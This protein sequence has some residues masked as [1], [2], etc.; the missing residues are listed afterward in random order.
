VCKFQL[1]CQIVQKRRHVEMC[2]GSLARTSL[3]RNYT[4]LTFYRK[5]RVFQTSFPIKMLR[6]T[7]AIFRCN[8]FPRSKLCGKLPQNSAYLLYKFVIFSDAPKDSVHNHT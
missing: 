7:C 2:C 1:F 8:C 4:Q 3:H 5:L 6:G